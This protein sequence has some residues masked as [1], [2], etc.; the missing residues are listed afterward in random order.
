MILILIELHKMNF[1]RFS[2]HPNKSMSQSPEISLFAP[3]T[4]SPLMIFF[5]FSGPKNTFKLLIVHYF[6]EKTLY[7]YFTI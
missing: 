5:A 4:G 2:N 3:F 6:V 1:P 7:L